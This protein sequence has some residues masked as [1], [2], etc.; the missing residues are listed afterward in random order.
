MEAFSS[1][2]FSAI[3]YSHPIVP[4]LQSVPLPF[5]CSGPSQSLPKSQP[6]LVPPPNPTELSKKRR[7]Q[8]PRQKRTTPLPFPST[9]TTKA[10]HFRKTK[11]ASPSGR[12]DIIVE[13]PSDLLAE[14]LTAFDLSTVLRAFLIQFNY[15]GIGTGAPSSGCVCCSLGS[16]SGRRSSRAPREAPPHSPKTPL[17]PPSQS[18][19]APIC[20]HPPPSRL[21]PPT[22]T[23][24]SLGRATVFRPRHDLRWTR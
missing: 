9:S 20:P 3:D 1:A 19:P 17:P 12:L 2:A 7:A 21:P 4:G 6:S 18:C 11:N 24:T 13:Q 10:R 22:L 14:S 8:R 15:I 5:L 23:T 16:G